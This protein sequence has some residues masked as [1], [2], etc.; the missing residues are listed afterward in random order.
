MVFGSLLSLASRVAPKL[1]SGVGEGMKA[2]AEAFQRGAVFLGAL[3]SGAKRFGVSVLDTAAEELPALG[4]LL[5]PLRSRLVDTREDTMR[6]DATKVAAPV[7]DTART[8]AA[9]AP[10]GFMPSP[11]AAKASTPSRSFTM[12]RDVAR[13]SRASRVG[14]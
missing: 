6:A 2:G 12:S 4:G 7:I 13:R 10:E 1:I 9:A 8:A 11:A 3:K 14:L 5:N